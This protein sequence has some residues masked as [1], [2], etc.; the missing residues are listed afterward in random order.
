MYSA[1][2]CN[3]IS[4]ENYARIHK[5]VVQ[6]SSLFLSLF[7]IHFICYYYLY[8]FYGICSRKPSIS[9]FNARM[10]YQLNCNCTAV[11]NNSLSI[12][13]RLKHRIYNFLNY[14]TLLYKWMLSFKLRRRGGAKKVHFCFLITWKVWT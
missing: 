9:Y 11:H 10:I 12:C 1:T 2:N 8:K 3:Q 7:F 4:F 14:F 5:E 13:L 6:D